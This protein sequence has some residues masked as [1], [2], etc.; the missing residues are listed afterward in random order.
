MAG[1]IR[2]E[3]RFRGPTGSG[4]GG[5][6]AGRLAERHLAAAGDGP[7]QVTLRRPPPLDTPLTVDTDGDD[8]RLLA[9][10]GGVVAEAVAGTLSDPV[11]PVDVEAAHRAE[12]DYAGFRNHPFPECFTCGTARTEGDGMRVFPGPLGSG[13]TACTWIPHPAMAGPDG[14]LD[15]AYVWA[16]LD[17][18][19]G[20]TGDLEGRPMVLGRMTAQVDARPVA[21]ETHIAVG[22]LLG[23]DGRK[24][25]T[26]STVYDSGGRVIGTAVHVWIAIDPARFS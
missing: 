6:T 11:S 26:A 5:W 3:R 4:N 22:R 1:E 10:D 21:G 16:A 25:S 8:T 15:P 13:R 17:C 9:A 24:T 2:I 18:P 19:G 7:I 20:W 23:V 12:R 14:R